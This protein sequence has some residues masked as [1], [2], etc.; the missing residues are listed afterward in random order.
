MT[1][2]VAAGCEREATDAPEI[3]VPATGW[4]ID[5]KRALRAILGTP[6]CREHV[7]AF[8][9]GDVLDQPNPNGEG[10]F[11]SVVMPAM[12]R[13]SGSKIPP[14][15]ARAWIHPLRLDSDDYLAFQRMADKG[16]QT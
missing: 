7:E 9:P 11:G 6:L 1:K 12:A 4:P 15:L 3:C 2:C 16:A 13:M 5:R 10:T 14:D 8:K